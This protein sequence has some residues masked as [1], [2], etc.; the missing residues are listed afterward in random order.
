MLT[1][2]QDVHPHKKLAYLPVEMITLV[3]PMIDTRRK[4]SR[5]IFSTASLATLVG[6][7]MSPVS[8]LAQFGAWLTGQ[9]FSMLFG[10]IANYVRAKVVDPMVHRGLDWT[11][12]KLQHL[13]QKY[14]PRIYETLA[15][16]LNSDSTNG[17]RE[18]ALRMLAQ[19]SLEACF[20]CPVTRQLGHQALAVVNRVPV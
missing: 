10:S 15:G 20:R 9:A 2:Y 6:A 17:S 7:S 3:T 5:R 14:G 16:I 13:Y 11:I 1:F 18:Q 19:H 12:G 4:I 8:A